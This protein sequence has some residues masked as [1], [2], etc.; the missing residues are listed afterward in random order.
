[1]LADRPTSAIPAN[2]SLN[3]WE[4]GAVLGFPRRLAAGLRN[5]RYIDWQAD[6]DLFKILDISGQD[7][8]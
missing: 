7:L 5:R 1:M 6:S 8:F 2:Q 3:S 4:G